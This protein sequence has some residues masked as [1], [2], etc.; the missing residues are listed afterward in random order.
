MCANR[1]AKRS[2][3]LRGIGVLADV[4]GCFYYYFPIFGNFNI[5]GIAYYRKY[6]YLARKLNDM[7]S[8]LHPITYDTIGTIEKSPESGLYFAQVID[9]ANDFK[10][11]SE[12]K[13]FT[14]KASAEAWIRRE[15]KKYEQ[16]IEEIVFGWNGANQGA[17][18]IIKDGNIS[19]KLTF[20]APRRFYYSLLNE[21]ESA[22]FE[23]FP[24]Y[25]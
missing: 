15:W 14:R 18:A 9:G 13:S 17:K 11:V 23:Q 4:G 25:A 21:A 8:V 24:Q 16:G 1:R 3:P 6:T 10:E 7:E 20:K 19:I 5:L 22:F 2:A 12:L